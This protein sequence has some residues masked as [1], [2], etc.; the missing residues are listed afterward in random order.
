MPGNSQNGGASQ[1]SGPYSGNPF[2][3]ST[4]ASQRDVHRQMFETLAV[5]GMIAGVPLEQVLADFEARAPK[6]RF[7]FIAMREGRRTAPSLA[8][9]FD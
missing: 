8:Q 6:V 7:Y 1:R 3:Q 5:D 9:G 4:A 2:S